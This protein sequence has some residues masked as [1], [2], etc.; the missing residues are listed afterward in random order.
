MKATSGR[1]TVDYD[2]VIKAYEFAGRFRYDESNTKYLKGIED[3]VQEILARWERIK[4]PEFDEFIKLAL[5]D[6]VARKIRQ[7]EI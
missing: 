5:A 3:T 7:R 4:G 6:I 1:F 2:Q